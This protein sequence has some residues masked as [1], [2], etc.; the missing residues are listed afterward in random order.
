MVVTLSRD[1]D[2][3]LVRHIYDLHMMREHLDIAAVAALVRDIATADADAF[4]NQCP[5]YAAD[6]AIKSGEA[7]S[8]A[9]QATGRG[10]FTPLI[11]RRNGI[12]C[13]QGHEPVAPAQEKGIGANEERAGMRSRTRETKAGSKSPSASASFTVNFV[14]RT[15]APQEWTPRRPGRPYP[16][17]P[18]RL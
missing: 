11:H 8:I 9:C 3:T 13:R 15:L 6:L 16:T 1:P 10:E 12:A 14:S 18:W 4:R 7:G 17:L 2:S 5:A